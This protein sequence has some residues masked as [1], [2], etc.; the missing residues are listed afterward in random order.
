MNPVMR[1]LLQSPAHRL[2]SGQ[3]ML[4]EY[5]GRMTGRTYVIPIGYFAWGSGSV[6]SVSGTRWW[7]N[8]RDGRPVI[9]L[10]RGVRHAA[11]PTVIESADS[12]VD[13]FAEFVSHYGPKVASRL[14]AGC[15]RIETRRRMNFARLPVRRC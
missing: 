8:L 9:L 15:P 1:R 13:L 4:L 5:T 2:L 14:G 10:V 7:R 6:L 11:V 12:R 3:L